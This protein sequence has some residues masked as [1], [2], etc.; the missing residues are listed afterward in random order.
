M[1]TEY[2][3]EPF[4]AAT[5][6]GTS[7]GNELRYTGREDD[8]TGI[9]YYR[10]RYYHPGLQRFI[11]EDPIGFAGGDSNLY[12][13]VGNNPI[14]AT[15]PTGEYLRG[16]AGM[17]MPGP[18]AWP[19]AGRKTEP[20]DLNRSGALL[21]LATDRP[22]I[23]VA[24]VQCAVQAAPLIAAAALA[25]GALVAEAVRQI[26]FPDISFAKDETKTAD[27]LIPG[28]GKRAPTY[29]PPYGPKTYREIK[30]L[31]KKGDRRAKDMKKLIERE[32]SGRDER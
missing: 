16:T 11:S 30:D 26:E 28:T 20:S 25:A 22:P 4:G 9:Y 1:P 31:A 6:S 32:Y 24:C 29:Y 5:A 15:D 18:S 17:P 14:T 13:Y 3:Y 2:S 8:G 10:A 27:Q 12:A 19:L 21:G 7:S 23:I